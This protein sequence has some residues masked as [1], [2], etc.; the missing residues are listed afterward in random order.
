MNGNGSNPLKT[1]VVAFLQ[2]T[3]FLKVPLIAINL[4]VILIEI[5][6]GG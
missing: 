5:V 2:A 6:A 3:S 4:I 1:Q